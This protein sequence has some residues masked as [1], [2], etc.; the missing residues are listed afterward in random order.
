MDLIVR[1]DDLTQFVDQLLDFLNSSEAPDWE[2]LDFYNLLADF[3]G[4]PR[5][6]VAIFKIRTPGLCI[7]F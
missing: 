7:Y 2:V 5:L 4:M 6:F 3:S 1:P